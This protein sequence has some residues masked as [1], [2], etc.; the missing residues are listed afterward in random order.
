[1]LEDLQSCGYLFKIDESVNKEDI[2]KKLKFE[3]VSVVEFR[4]IL[5][6]SFYFM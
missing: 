5:L 2:L 6:Y 4:C 3:N 1:M